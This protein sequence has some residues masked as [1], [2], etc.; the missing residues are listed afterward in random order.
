MNNKYITDLNARLVVAEGTSK[1]G[2]EYRL[3]KVI[4]NTELYGEVEILLDTRHD[5][6]GIILDMLARHIC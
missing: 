3:T 2:K 4:I 1:N 6:A 5:R